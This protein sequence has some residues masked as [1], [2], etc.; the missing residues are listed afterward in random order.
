MPES[1]VAQ[2]VVED[3]GF[4]ESSL[5]SVQELGLSSE[6]LPVTSLGAHL[7]AALIAAA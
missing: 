3:L 5:G 4:S 2:F 7:K 6:D 1:Q